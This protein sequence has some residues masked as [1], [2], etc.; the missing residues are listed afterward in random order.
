MKKQCVLLLA[1][2]LA[3]GVP[4]GMTSSDSMSGFTAQAQNNKVTGVVRDTN[5]DPLI[6]ATVMVK[7]TNRG[8]ATDIDGRYSIAATPGSTLMIS[9]IGS[10][11]MEVKV[12]GNNMDITMSEAGNTTLDEVVVTALG[13]KKDRKSLGYA[14]DDLK[15]EELMRNKTAN[16][17][18]S[19]SGK[20]AGVNITQSSGAAG[21]GAQIILRGGTSGAESRDNQPLFVVDGVIYDNSSSI[22]GNTG[23]DGTGTAQTTASNRVMDINPE[24]IEN[25]SILKGPAASALY[26]SRAANGVVLITTKKGKEGTVE[27]NLNAKYITSRAARLP[28]VQKDFVRGYMDDIYDDDGNFVE[29]RFNDFSYNSWGKYDPNAT[30]YDNIADFFETGGIWDTNLSISGGNKNG[31][32]Y[33]SGSYYD[34]D[35]IVPTTGYKKTTFRFN[36]EQKYKIFTVGANAA[37]SDARTVRTLTGAA[38]YGSS[39]TGALYAVYNWSPTDNMSHYL[40]E[41]GTRYRMFG[42]RLQPWEERDNPYWIVNKNRMTDATERFTGSFNVRADLFDWWWINYRMGVDSYT[43]ENINTIAPSGAIQKDWQNGM[44]SDNTMRYRYLTT[45]LMTNWNKQFG[46][47][48]FNLMLGT[49]T[50]YTKSVRNYQMAWNFAVPNFFSFDNADTN[51]KKFQ[52]TMSRKRLVA[53][54]GE[55]RVDWRNAIFLTV[56][57]RNDWTSTLPVENRSYFY[58]SVSGAIAFT[59]LMGESRPDWLSFGKVR[60]SWA[61]VGKDTG[62]YETNTYL[63]PVYNFLLGKVGMGNSWERGN[64]Y[65]K[66]EM[67]E[68]TEIG[69]ELRFLQN[70][71]KFDIA[72]YT[73]NSYNQ[74]LSPRGPQST[75]YIFCSIN[76]GNVY[77]K[78]LEISLGGTPVQ[79]Q[80][81]TWE[82]NL[83]VAGNRGTMKNLPEGME[84][85]YLTDVQY[86]SAKAASISGGSFMAISGSKWKRVRDAE[87]PYYNE[88]ILDANGMPQAENV[89]GDAWEVGN[90]EAKFSGG[91]NNTL[92][93][94]N[95][96]FNMLWEFRVGGDVFNGTKYQMT[97][98][99]VSEF[100]GQFRQE[101][102]TISG[103]YNNGSD[104][105]PDYTP[106]TNTWDPDKNYLFNKKTQSG[107]N[108][109][110]SY[111]TGAYNY[112]TANW[113]TKVNSLRLRTISLSYDIPRSVLAKTKVIKRAILTASASNLL[114]FTNYDG[115]PEVAASGAGRGGSSSVGFEYCGVPSTRQ[116]AFGVNL[117][118]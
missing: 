109:I 10:K 88:L 76:A 64:P 51:N 28:K 20:I 40:N 36:G 39:G 9:Y 86:G 48:D 57:G 94:K 13:I 84:F 69:L 58:P 47:F 111:Y 103:V 16:A 113:I 97:Q 115:D 8:T 71:L 19:L 116:F 107:L 53:V 104:A 22:I 56:T 79:T 27:I 37:Y 42:D 30:R 65:I 12:T 32:F 24:D 92:T 101:S 100:S 52:H 67:S 66:P 14:I 50:D 44:L 38:L 4:A 98:S 45:N 54:F 41:D 3:C 34:Q 63:W 105:E 23:F 117:T 35:G 2:A 95:W 33:F 112:E 46:D 93:W 80:D 75:G 102:L 106:V 59:E 68:S 87:S 49:S 31:N 25:M 89:G 74:I 85:M 81:F 7:G 82:T 21:A 43:Q 118:F 62:A 18:N 1:L 110:E 11:P 6:G 78:G 99:G 114:L 70:R 91:W 72:Y 55:F 61:R 60:A 26:G 73:N 29:S 83:N 77:N 108:I 96:S 15:A 5:G 17:I 90:R